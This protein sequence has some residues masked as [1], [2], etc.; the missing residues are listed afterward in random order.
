MWFK[1]ERKG[2]SS[3]DWL[4]SHSIGRKGKKGNRSTHICKELISFL[5]KERNQGVADKAVEFVQD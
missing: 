4:S 2:E 3:T 1:E 5:K